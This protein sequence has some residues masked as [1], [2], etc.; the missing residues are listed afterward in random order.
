MR[1]IFKYVVPD[2]GHFTV[3]MPRGAEVLTMQPQG[4]GFVFWARVDT[5]Q[6]MDRRNF[7][8]AMTGSDLGRAAQWNYVDSAQTPSFMGN[9]VFHLLAE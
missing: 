9:L 2:A 8:L 1:K 4:D 6:P 5:D 3:E 7:F